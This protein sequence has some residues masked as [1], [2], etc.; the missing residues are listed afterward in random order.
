[1]VTHRMIGRDSDSA[2]MVRL[3]YMIRVKSLEEKIFWQFEQELLEF[4]ASKL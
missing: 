1:M 4:R 2:V 3:V